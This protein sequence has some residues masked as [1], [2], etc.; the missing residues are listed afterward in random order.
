MSIVVAVI[1][2]ATCALGVPPLDSSGIAL[3]FQVS[4]QLLNQQVVGDV[5]VDMGTSLGKSG[6]HKIHTD[7]AKE[8]R[9]NRPN[10]RGLR[11]VLTITVASD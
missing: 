4:Q 11:P 3:R 7:N 5:G 10:F 2:E 8:N 6:T 1:Q 9:W